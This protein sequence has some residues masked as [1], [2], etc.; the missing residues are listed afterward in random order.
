MRFRSDSIESSSQ[1][2]I[3]ASVAAMWAGATQESLIQRD[4]QSV[5][6]QKPVPRD[7]RLD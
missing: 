1:L 4:P 7:E 6:V 2:A 5:G 3:I